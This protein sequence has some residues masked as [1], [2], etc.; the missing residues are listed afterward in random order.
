M[1]LMES[2]QRG[3]VWGN[4]IAHVKSACDV[5]GRAEPGKRESGDLVDVAFYRSVPDSGRVVPDTDDEVPDSVQVVPDTGGK[6]PD[7][8]QTVPDTGVKVPDSVALRARIIFEHIEQHGHISAPEVATLLAVK[9]R[10]ARAV[11]KEMMDYGLLG[12]RSAA[13]QTVYVNANEGSIKP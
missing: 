9:E 6:V 13:R 12:K 2:S 11:L 10:R 8:V 3:E 7:S 1:N 5:Q 4:G